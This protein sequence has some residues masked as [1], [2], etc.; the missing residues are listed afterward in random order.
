MSV[1]KKSKR[2]EFNNLKPGDCFRLTINGPIYMKDE[3]N[4]GLSV[5]G[6]CLGRVF[7]NFG[8]EDKK[9]VYPAKVKIVEEKS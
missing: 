1:K 5:T 9:S 8:F 2:V 7:Y 3:C 6:K 4:C